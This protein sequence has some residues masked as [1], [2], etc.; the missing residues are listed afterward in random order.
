M[1]RTSTINYDAQSL[2]I[3]L[4]PQSAM[5][6]VHVPWSDIEVVRQ[7]KERKR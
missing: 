4:F 1:R 7:P 2:T 5:L 6:A 3:S